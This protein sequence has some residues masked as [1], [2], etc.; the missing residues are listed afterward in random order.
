MYKRSN[1]PGIQV[2]VNDL[3]IDPESQNLQLPGNY[4]FERRNRCDDYNFLL[5]T[6]LLLLLLFLIDYEE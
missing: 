1:R 4:C 6:L 5:L 2:T 3:W